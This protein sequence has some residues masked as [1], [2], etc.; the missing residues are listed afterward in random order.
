MTFDLYN[1]ISLGLILTTGLIVLWEDMQTNK[2]RNVWILCLF[3]LGGVFLG[4]AYIRGVIDL[5]YVVTVVL[6]TAFSFVA[7]FVIWRLGFWSAG[8]S[9]LFTA[10]SFVLPLHYYWKT[11]LYFFPSFVLLINAFVLFLIFLV[12]KSL[13]LMG[14]ALTVSLK[15]KRCSLE[16]MRTSRAQGTE[17]FCAYVGNFSNVKRVFGNL[18]AKLTIGLLVYVLFF[19]ILARQSFHP[20]LFLAYSAVFLS[21]NALLSYYAKYHTRLR[22]PVGDLKP[23]CNLS[24]QTLAQL[25]ADPT[26]MRNLGTLRAEGITADQARLIKDYFVVREVHEIEIMNTIPFSPWIVGGVLTTIAFK[27]N[28]V[29]LITSLF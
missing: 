16:N 1:Y 25:R 5:I 15:G 22:I 29:Q 14:R 21:L 6:N 23:R 7:G 17:T 19:V 24:D 10:F 26:L 4:L 27:G 2:I 13:F 8:D 9:K 28:L 11:Y 12:L 20:G 18:S 3:G